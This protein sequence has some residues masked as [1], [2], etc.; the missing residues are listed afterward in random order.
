MGIYRFK[1]FFK[2]C[3]IGIAV[4]L[5]IVI[6]SPSNAVLFDLSPSLANPMQLTTEPVN[7]YWP[8][9]S[10]D[11]KQ[12]LYYSRI[13]DRRQI[14]IRDVDG[15][16]R[17]QL[18]NDDA[19]N[20]D[21]SWSTDGNYIVWSAKKKGGS[22]DIWIMNADGSGATQ[23]TSDKADELHPRMSPV[24][25]LLTPEASEPTDPE[26]GGVEGPSFGPYYR[27]LYQKG[28]GKRASIWSMWNDGRFPRQVSPRG[29]RARHAEW[30]PDGMSIAYD[31]ETPGGSVIYLGR[32]VKSTTVHE[33]SGNYE[34]LT[35]EQLLK[36]LPKEFV[37]YPA[38]AYT[39]PKDNY[40]HPAFFA[41]NTGLFVVQTNRDKANSFNIHAINISPYKS[42][43]VVTNDGVAF[44]PTWSP[45]GDKVAFT[46][47]LGD[48]SQ[49]FVAD[50]RMYLSQVLNLF[51]YPE[52]IKHPSAKL[53]RNRFVI[54]TNHEAEFFHL[55]EKVRYQ[56]KG[57]FISVDPLMQLYHDMFEGI[58]IKVEKQGLSADLLKLSKQMYLAASRRYG[59]HS[60]GQKAMWG[61]LAVYFA[62]PYSLLEANGKGI[63]PVKLPPALHLKWQKRIGAIKAHAGLV[64][65]IDFSQFKPRGH[66][67]DHGQLSAYF[68][69]MMW[70]GTVP[71]R[72]ADTY[73]AVYRQLRDDKL[74]AA[75]EKIYR[76]TSY[77]SG[78]AE[79]PTF[80]DLQKAEAGNPALKQSAPSALVAA[81]LKN[82]GGNRIA[83]VTVAS[84]LNDGKGDEGFRGKFKFM[85]QRYSVDADILQH[86]VAPKIPGRS[87]PSSLDIFSAF[88]SDRALEHLYKV[89]ANEPGV[90]TNQT[91]HR[92]AIADLRSA[93]D[94]R[95][96]EYW[97]ANLYN[98]WLYAVEIMQR[99]PSVPGNI[100]GGRLPEF[101]T[102][103]AWQ[104][105]QFITAAASYTELKH[106]T[107]LYSKQP[108]AAEGAEGGEVSY[109][110]E[111]VLEKKPKG[112]V[113]PTI[114]L[115]SWLQALTRRTETLMKQTGYGL[116][117]H[118][119]SDEI[120]K[121]LQDASTLL[122]ELERLAVKE[123]HGQTLTDNEYQEIN[124]FGARLES[125][126]IESNMAT[127][128]GGTIMK[129]G[130]DRLQNGIKL[131][132]DV[133]T[134]LNT[135]E[136]LEE[137]V[138]DVNSLYVIT[139]HEDGQYLNQGG[140]FSYY[141]FTQP[142]SSRL[143]DN[144]WAQRLDSRQAPPMPSW[145]QDIVEAQ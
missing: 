15:G 48:T 54:R 20:R 21:P 78:E 47:F 106:D 98:G 42:M 121:V 59:L 127:G 7:S 133:L 23:L 39:D 49:I 108:Y 75:W 28:Q 12:V 126:Y 56:E 35:Q 25:F 63:T 77:F 33:A 41:N 61:E 73:G 26:F 50:S 122:D 65:G 18:T 13:D 10:P 22:Y 29:L 36:K 109:F 34:Q 119:Y 118:D 85:P 30:A 53:Q 46:T 116:G 140:V 17:R 111:S 129:R 74:L 80:L 19:D 11:G 99:P 115:Y 6:P 8:R 88:G 70:Y 32:S 145:T 117:E 110:L 27:I 67:D 103:A 71:F 113:E 138:G 131:V 16:N 64:D 100:P 114:E 2:H 1:V 94:S 43:P 76:V 14:F 107:I 95:P 102:N 91:L 84:A 81:A 44:A 60:G 31:V 120:D 69:A 112:Y 82:T 51:R 79:D 135:G 101:A 92:K 104:D 37:T 72:N 96:P 57:V 141:E 86:V 143:T 9:F 45:R 123:V 90:V 83:D 132:A 66:Y 125:F 130:H 55:L 89:G 124:R 40:S 68:S 87:M 142:M 144:E 5:V 134:S 105:K 128:G 136:V 93:L 58:L 3:F 52:L 97:T 139:P 137:A 24:R 62:V 38:R 4:F